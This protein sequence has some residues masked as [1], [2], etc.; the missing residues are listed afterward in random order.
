MSKPRPQENKL[1]PAASSFAS[2]LPQEISGWQKTQED[3]VFSRENIFDYI[4]GAGEIYLAYDFRFVFVREFAKQNAPSIVVEIYQ[5][6][7]SE[8][9]FGVFTQDTDGDDVELGQGAIYAA[10]LLRFWKD[11]IFVRILA[12]KETP[13]SKSTVMKLG[14]MIAAAVPQEGRRPGLISALPSE[15][16]KPKSLR[17][18]HTLISLN[19]HYFLASENILNLSPETEAV[20]AQYERGKSRARLLLVA[21]PSSSKADAANKQFAEIYLKEKAAPAGKMQSIELGDGK[22]S[23][24]MRKGRFLILILEAETL[25]LCERLSKEIS[26][27]L[28]DK[29]S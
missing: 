12:G 8:D 19:S 14:E 20:L 24:V 23:S 15:G 2:I 27:R 7:S 4:D 9:A 13:E 18:F 5:M 1:P 17:F 22:F 6:S 10:G 16:L 21:Y 11:K 29:D 26:Q 25:P 28:E 3:Q